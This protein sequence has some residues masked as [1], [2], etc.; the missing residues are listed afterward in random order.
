VVRDDED[1]VVAMEETRRSAEDTQLSY[2]IVPTS[3]VP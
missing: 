2:T 1:R 3:A